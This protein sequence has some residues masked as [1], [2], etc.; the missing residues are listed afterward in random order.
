MPLCDKNQVIFATELPS[1]TVVSLLHLAC[2]GP[3][4]FEKV[5]IG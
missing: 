4:N 5:Y 1:T 2:K 3:G